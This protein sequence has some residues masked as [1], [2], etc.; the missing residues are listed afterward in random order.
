[1]IVLRRCESPMLTEAGDV[2]PLP[3]PL[4]PMTVRYP[5]ALQSLTSFHLIGE[6]ELRSASPE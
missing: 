6:C 1:M 3:K 2:R 5:V 4:N